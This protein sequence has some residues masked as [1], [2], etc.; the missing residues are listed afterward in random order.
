MGQALD[1]R[2]IAVC[3]LQQ[4][5]SF[6]DKKFLRAIDKWMMGVWGRGRGEEHEKGNDCELLDL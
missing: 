3:L 1:S 6:T 4:S 2:E 5:V